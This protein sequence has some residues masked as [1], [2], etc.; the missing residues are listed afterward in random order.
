MLIDSYKDFLEKFFQAFNAAGINLDNLDLDHLGYQT[1]SSEDYE[2]IKSELLSISLLGEETT[3]NDRRIGIFILNNPIQYNDFSIDI[4]EVIEPE[5]GENRESDWE[6]V[7]FTTKDMIETLIELYPNLDWDKS[8]LHRDRFQMLKLKLS[9]GL[10]IKFPRK[11]LKSQMTDKGL[12][13]N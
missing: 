12:Y 2:K 7:E 5:K 8:A 3:F 1:S 6:H 9:N 10:R 4:I 13:S 11:G